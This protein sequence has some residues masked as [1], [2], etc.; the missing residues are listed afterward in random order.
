MKSG[1][2][3]FNI[4]GERTTADV[5]KEAWNSV[6]QQS[7]TYAE[8]MVETLNPTLTEKRQKKLYEDLIEGLST[9]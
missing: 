5:K 4:D 7:K 3:D 2:Y 6:L 8:S 1:A 9:Y